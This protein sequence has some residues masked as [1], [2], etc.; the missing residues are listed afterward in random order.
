VGY[1]HSEGISSR[2]RMQGVLAILKTSEPSESITI[3]FE[4]QLRVA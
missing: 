4:V 2:G 3:R 1:F